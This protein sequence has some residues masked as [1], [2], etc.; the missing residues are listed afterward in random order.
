MYWLTREVALRNHQ[1]IFCEGPVAYILHDVIIAV[2]EKYGQPIHHSKAH[3]KLS[4]FL[5]KNMLLNL[6]LEI[7]C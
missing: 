5:S 4:N 2:S 6:G 7:Y 1:T 3:D